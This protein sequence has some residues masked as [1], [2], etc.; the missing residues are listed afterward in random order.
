[1]A[2]LR[3]LPYDVSSRRGDF[4]AKLSEDALLLPREVS[5]AAAQQGIRTAEDLLS[6]LQAF[7]TAIASQLQWRNEDVTLATQR[8]RQQ[9]AGRVNPVHL[10]QTQRPNP[11]FGARPPRGKR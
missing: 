6:Y 3:I 2:P 9:L 7:P 10:D 1:M 11:P 8:L 4:Q 5:D